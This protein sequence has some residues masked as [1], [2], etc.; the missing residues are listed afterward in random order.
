MKDSIDLRQYFFNFSVEYLV[1]VAADDSF[2]VVEVGL[3][4]LQVDVGVVDDVI[5]FSKPLLVDHSDCLFRSD[6]S[7]L[8]IDGD[9]Q[10]EHRVLDVLVE[11][12]ESAAVDLEV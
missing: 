1:F 7:L 8:D 12:E 4:G 10:V 2:I 9:V 5:L 6:Q 11:E 3:L